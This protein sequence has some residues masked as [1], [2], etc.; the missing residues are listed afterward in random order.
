M[1]TRNASAR[2]RFSL[3]SISLKSNS[4]LIFLA[5]V[6]ALTAALAAQSPAARPI[7]R[8]G[9][10]QVVQ[11]FN[12]PARWIR[13][14][15]WVETTFDSDGDGKRDRVFVDVTRPGQTETERLKV[16]I[17]YESSPYFART[18]GGKEIPCLSG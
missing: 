11:A 15:L 2:S 8:N 5:G 16:P 13:Q 6:P 9:Q 14:S 1:P 7:F 3:P 4:L 10:A 12:D 17:I 18:S